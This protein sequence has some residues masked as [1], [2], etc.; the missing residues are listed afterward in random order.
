MKNTK[1]IKRLSAVLTV[2]VCLQGIVVV[3]DAASDQI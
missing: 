1:I 3:A 2:I